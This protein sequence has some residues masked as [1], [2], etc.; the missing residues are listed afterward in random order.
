MLQTRACTSAER[1]HTKPLRELKWLAGLTSQPWVASFSQLFK[2]KF[3]S[4]TM[5]INAVRVMVKVNN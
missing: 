3:V 2:C 1:D 4:D 5:S